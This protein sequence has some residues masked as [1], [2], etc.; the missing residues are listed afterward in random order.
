M[1]LITLAYD[2]DI[3]LSWM[4]QSK[5]SM[6]AKIRFELEEQ[7]FL[8]FAEGETKIKSTVSVSSYMHQLIYLMTR[9]MTRLWYRK[10]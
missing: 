9:V 5:R 10:C 7:K 8:E 4:E 1:I 2:S 6:G 3:V